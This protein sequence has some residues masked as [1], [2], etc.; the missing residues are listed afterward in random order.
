MCI[1]DR[2]C[3]KLAMPG[4]THREIGFSLTELLVV[5]A[6]I[7][8]L[9][10][11]AIP[12]F[13]GVLQSS[14]Q[15]IA[16]RNLN[17]LNGAVSAYNQMNRRLT[18]ADGQSLAVFAALTNRDEGIPGSPFLPPNL[19]AV[20]SSSTTAFRARWNGT[21]FAMLSTGASGSGIDLLRLSGQTN[22]P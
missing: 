17:L 8:I 11:V 14:T 20:E 1:R 12:I 22:S 21:V 4:A 10:T 7:A 5:V 19:T 3:G 2:C 9:A 16:R 6:V 18:N 13:T 15:D